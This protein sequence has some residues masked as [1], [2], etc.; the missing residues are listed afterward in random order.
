VGFSVADG[1]KRQY[2]KLGLKMSTLNNGLA[3]ITPILWLLLG[4]AQFML[5][6]GRF[7]LK[8]EQNSVEVYLLMDKDG[9]SK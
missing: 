5:R 1:A 3:F 2:H 9:G 7:R 6:G 8:W 4:L